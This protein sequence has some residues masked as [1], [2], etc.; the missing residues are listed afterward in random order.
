MLRSFLNIPL[1]FLGPGIPEITLRSTRS[2]KGEFTCIMQTYLH[3]VCMY[4]YIHL[5]WT[6]HASLHTSVQVLC[7]DQGI[8]V[9]INVYSTLFFILFIMHA[10]CMHAHASEQS[11]H[12]VYTASVCAAGAVHVLHIIF[13]CM[14]KFNFAWICVTP[15]WLGFF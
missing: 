1:L 5:Q 13:A 11:L 14:Y 12:A 4:L 15:H 2:S 7:M 8:C 6:V 3:A 10:L 9:Y